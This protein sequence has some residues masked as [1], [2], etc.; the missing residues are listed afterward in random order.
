MPKRKRK[1]TM[2]PAALAQRRGAAHKHG[3]YAQTAVAQ[4]LPPCRAGTCPLGGDR[5]PCSLRAAM[6]DKGEAVERCPLPLAEDAKVREL[7]QAIREGDPTKLAEGQALALVMAAELRDRG[8]KALLEEGL[9]VDKPIYTKDGGLVSSV[10]IQNPKAYPVLELLKHT[11]ATADQQGVTP[12]S[13]AEKQRDVS[14]GEALSFMARKRKA[15]E[16]GLPK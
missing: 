11:G 4:V 14:L 5:F 3:L 10:P 13:A 6:D 7:A 15:L 2:S 8:L 16:E 9:S 1:Y 12:K